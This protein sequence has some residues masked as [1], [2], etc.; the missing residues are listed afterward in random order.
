METAT[1]NQFVSEIFDTFVAVCSK[2]KIDFSTAKSDVKAIPITPAPAQAGAAPAKTDTV[3]AV[4]KVVTVSSRRKTAPDTVSEFIKWFCTTPADKLY[5]VKRGQWACRKDAGVWQ[6]TFDSDDKS[7]VSREGNPGRILA[8][9][10]LGKPELVMMNGGRISYGGGSRW[11][12]SYPQ[13]LAMDSMAMPIP[14]RLIMDQKPQGLGKK[15]ED[16]KVV[17][18][19]GQEDITV[20]VDGN[21]RRYDVHNWLEKRHFAGGA[22]IAIGDEYFLLDADRQE[23]GY[24]K[25]NAFFTKLPGP[26]KTIKEAYESLIPHEVKGSTFIRQGELFFRPVTDDVVKV[27]MKEC[28]NEEGK[29]TFDSTYDMLISLASSVAEAQLHGALHSDWEN[30]QRAKG[31]D[32]IIDRDATVLEKLTKFY[33]TPAA[34]DRDDSAQQLATMVNPVGFAGSYRLQTDRNIELGLRPGQEQRNR[35]GERHHVTLLFMPKPE[36]LYAFGTVTHQQ[37]YPVSLK[38]WH[39]VYHNAATGSWNITGE[40]D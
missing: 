28:A 38:Q 37:H 31:K 40:V 17:E 2:Y 30:I 1:A 7:A 15:I 34:K 16:V 10:P 27:R 23:L 21:R 18:W 6:L 35:W 14:L 4:A 22:V 26:V 39:R 36:E 32:P 25:L 9:R 11:G 19:T 20:A 29:R 3:V 33:K 12:V 8:F 24:F 5:Q 13:R